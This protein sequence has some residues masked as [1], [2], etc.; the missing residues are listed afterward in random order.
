MVNKQRLK[1]NVYGESIKISKIEIPI[2]WQEQWNEQI[3]MCKEPKQELLLDP[4][5][6]YKLNI[7]EITSYNDL[8]TKTWKGMK[9]T[10][11]SQLEI[12]SERKKIFK[13]SLSSIATDLTLFPLFNT[14]NS[15]FDLDKEGLFV[16]EI[17]KGMIFSCK[18][19]HQHALPIID[20]FLFYLSNWEGSVWLEKI[21]FRSDECISSVSDTII[22]S[23]YVYKI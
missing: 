1:I 16:V 3:K 11:Q 9:C 17:E 22:T 21:L 14:V 13:S 6:Y 8:T 18:V 2:N 19:E 10:N 5:F 15:S 23:Q 4:F 7:P 20:D 12:W